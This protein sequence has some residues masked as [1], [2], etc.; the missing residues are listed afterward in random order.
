MAANMFCLFLGKHPRGTSY[1]KKVAGYQ[2]LPGN[3]FLE[4]TYEIL[5][6]AFIKT[7]TNGDFCNKLVL[8][9]PYFLQ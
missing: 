6:T 7:P 3:V 1:F 9:L 4:K 2:R 5:K 8:K